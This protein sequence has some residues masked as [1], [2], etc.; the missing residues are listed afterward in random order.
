MALDP[1][2]APVE[3]QKEYQ[4]RLK[5]NYSINYLEPPFPWKVQSF[6]PFEFQLNRAEDRPPTGQQFA[7]GV[8]EFFGGGGSFGGAGA[9]SL[10]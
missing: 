4:A 5:K 1:S 8:S 9:G 3:T 2:S 10:F 6:N 7:E